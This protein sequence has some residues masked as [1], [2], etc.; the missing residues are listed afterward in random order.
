MCV[1]VCVYTGESV[2]AGEFCRANFIMWGEFFEGG[3]TLLNFTDFT[4]IFFPQ[5]VKF[6]DTF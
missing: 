5:T 3:H 2:P 1:F 4:L 6:I